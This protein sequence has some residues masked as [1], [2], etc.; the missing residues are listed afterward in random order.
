MT[1]GCKVNQVETEAME[2]LFI[3]KGYE[4][5]DFT[6]TADIYVIN[7]CS[8]TSLGEQKSRKFIHR[9]NKL[10]PDA[11]IAVVGC[12]AQANPDEVA[13]IKGVNVVIGSK[14]KG[15]I[16]EYVE[17]ALIGENINGVSDVKNNVEFEEFFTN[18]NP[19]RTRAFLKIEDGCESFCSYCIIPHLRGSVKSRSLDSI[20]KEAL[21][22]A[23]KGFLEIVLTGIHIGMYGKDTG[24]ALYDAI[25]VILENTKIP[26]LRLSSL[27][28]A[29]LSED[30]IDLAKSDKRLAPHFHLPLQSGSDKILK[31]MNRHYTTLDFKRVTES[32]TQNLPNASISTDIIVGF[33]GEDEKLFEET[34]DFVKTAPFSKIHVFPYSRRPGTPAAVMENQVSEVEKKRRVKILNELSQNK[35]REFMRKFMGKTLSVLFETNNDGVTDGLTDNYIRVY[36]KDKVTLNSIY[37]VIMDDFYKDGV[38]GRII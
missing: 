4:T 34:L 15:K 7:T 36:A 5:V 6:E 35:S 25:K 3:D 22:L 9:A 33:P 27:E 24:A 18:Y 8:V 23:E 13:N 26:R 37:N 21:N 2:S 19:Q 38:I 30:I 1:L 16:V 32:I 10:N 12:Y 20:K 17:K 29:E 31:A 14:D 11:V 28:S